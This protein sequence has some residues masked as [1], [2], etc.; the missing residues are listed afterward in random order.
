[1]TLLADRA[2]GRSV[3]LRAEMDVLVVLAN[4]PHVLDDR[5]E[6]G[7]TP[8]RVLAWSGGIAG[9]DDSIRNSSPEAM[10]AFQNPE[11]YLAQWGG[12]V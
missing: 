10:R 7:A 11:D 8:V 9:V 6:Y 1:M 4:T 5:P 3:E 12:R 2:P